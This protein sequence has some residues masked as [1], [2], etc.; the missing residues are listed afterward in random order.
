MMGEILQ[1]TA[2]RS[3]QYASRHPMAHALLVLFSV[4]CLYGIG[5]FGFALLRAPLVFPEWLLGAD[6]VVYLRGDV[7]PEEENAAWEELKSWP[8]WESIRRVSREETYARLEKQL[9]SWKGILSGVSRDHLQPSLELTFKHAFQDPERREETVSRLRLVPN[10][11]EILYGNGE[12]DKLKSLVGWIGGGL[13]LAAAVPALLIAFA[14]WGWTLVM[15]AG[16]R[17]E[18]KVQWWVGAPNWMMTLP[19]LWSSW[20]AGALG[21]ILAQVLLAATVHFLETRLPLPFAALFAG[22]RLEW[23]ILGCGMTGVAWFMGSLGVWLTRREMRRLC[24]DDRQ[25]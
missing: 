2:R 11:T 9:G 25:S 8:E 23:L 22:D 15:M 1:H 20:A 14:H 21:S 10:V 16:A 3:R 19:F 7:S 12:G 6:A 18:L 5:V 13:W 17:D 4:F 24:G